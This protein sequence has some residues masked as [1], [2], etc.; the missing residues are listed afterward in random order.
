M[1]FENEFLNQDSAA[2]PLLEM[3]S[4]FATEVSDLLLEANLKEEEWKEVDEIQNE[5]KVN[6]I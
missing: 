4:M 3:L 1:D 2:K 5:L 6:N